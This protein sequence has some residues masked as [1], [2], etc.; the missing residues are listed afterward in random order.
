M[1]Y[2]EVPPG[3]P[4][5]HTA[6]IHVGLVQLQLSAVKVSD[7]LSTALQLSRG[8]AGEAANRMETVEIPV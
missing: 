2:S 4:V 6:Y 7:R 8:R 5:P 3:V 1:L